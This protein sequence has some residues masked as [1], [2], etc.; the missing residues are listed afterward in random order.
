[1]K[2]LLLALTLATTTAALAEDAPWKPLFEKDGPPA[3]FVVRHW[4]DVGQPAQGNPV[5]QVKD[6]VL[7]SAG[8]RGCWLMSEKPYTDFE[9]EYEFKLGPTGNSGLALRAPLQ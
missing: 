1:M 2:A 3:G 6:G 8:D 9:L 4:A 7:T 5:W